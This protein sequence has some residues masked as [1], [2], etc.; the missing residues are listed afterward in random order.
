MLRDVGVI[1]RLVFLFL[2]LDIVSL[3]QCG[4]TTPENSIFL[5]LFQAELF[6]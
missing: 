2:V 5:S 3:L 4:G 1:E 6:I